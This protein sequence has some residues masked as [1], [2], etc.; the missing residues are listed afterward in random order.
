METLTQPELEMKRMV[1]EN[2]G[3]ANFEFCDYS[4]MDK[5]ICMDCS[6]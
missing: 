6:E 5:Y 3:E 2:C 4:L 1:C